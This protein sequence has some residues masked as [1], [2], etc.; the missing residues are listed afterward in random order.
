MNRHL[1]RNSPWIT[2]IVEGEI[3]GKPERGRI[4]PLFLKEV[5]EDTGIGTY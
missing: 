2:A 4:N 3:E 1:I 5:M